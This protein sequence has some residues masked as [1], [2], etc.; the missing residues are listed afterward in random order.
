MAGLDVPA[1]AVVGGQQRDE[2]AV[3][4]SAAQQHFKAIQAEGFKTLEEVQQVSFVTERGQKKAQ[5]D[6]VQIEG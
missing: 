6:Q 1:S 2:V 4:D 5:A 3:K